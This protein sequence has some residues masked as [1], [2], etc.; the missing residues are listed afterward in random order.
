MPHQF[1]QEN[2]VD[3]FQLPPLDAAHPGTEGIQITIG[4]LHGNAMKLMFMLVKHGI[5]KHLN[6]EDY[7]K[8]VRIYTIPVEDLTEGILAEYNTI[9]SEIEFST[10]SLVRLIGDELADRGSNDYFTLKILEKLTQHG[11]RVEIILSNHSIEFIE[12]Y[13][14]HQNF[15]APML[16]EGGHA[17]SM[18]ALEILVKKGIVRRDE[19]LAI[20]NQSYKPTLRAISYSLSEDK[21]EITIYSHA[22]IGLDT[23]ELLAEKLKV[24]YQDSTTS[25]LAQTI[26]NINEQFQIHVQDNTVH[27]LYTPEKMREGYEGGTWRDRPDL[28]DEPLTFIMWNRRYTE[29]NRPAEHLGYKVC[30][31]HGHD[32]NDR[33]YGH[34]YNLDNYLGKVEGLNVGEYTVL[35]S[36]VNK[37]VP[38]IKP[39][40]EVEVE[41]VA[42]AKHTVLDL[43]AV[44]IEGDHTVSSSRE[45]EITFS[46]F[47]PTFKQAGLCALGG[48]AALGGAALLSVL[49][50]PL[51]PIAAQC[52]AVAAICAL[53]TA[54]IIAVAAAITPMPQYDMVPV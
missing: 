7:A 6:A 27:T 15:H 18:E 9:L 44:G 39:I 33:S 40:E 36:R 21:T 30:F 3:I 31:A 47:K 2:D 25:E 28:S 48:M 43:G 38:A 52:L 37:M 10:D 51:V 41:V 45:N 12:A 29:I 11:V 16:S 50:G 32:S 49:F 14:K 26:D 42:A 19:I 5:A 35:Y 17:P 1:I 46:L 23:I 53:L 22:A 24:E 20:A 13:E 8:L 54:A 34:L 4:D